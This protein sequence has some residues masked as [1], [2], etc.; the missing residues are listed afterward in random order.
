MKLMKKI[1]DHLEKRK[2]MFYCKRCKEWV[3]EEKKHNNKK[4]K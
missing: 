3:P 2:Y 1:G 4:H